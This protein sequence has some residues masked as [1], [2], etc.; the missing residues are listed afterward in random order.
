MTYIKFFCG[1]KVYNVDGIP[2]LI[3][4]I[5]GNL[6]KGKILNNDFT[7]TSCYVV[8]QEGCFAHGYTLRAAREAVLEKVF[9]NM[10]LKE[11]INAFVD[12]HDKDKVYPNTDLFEWHHKLTGSCLPGRE[13]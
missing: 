13:A 7:C 8:K 3:D 12:A 6:A 4:K 1:Q 9:E 5:R 2:T 11:R 10:P